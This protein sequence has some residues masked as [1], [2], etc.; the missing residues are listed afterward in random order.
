MSSEEEFSWAGRWQIVQRK[1]WLCIAISLMLLVLMYVDVVVIKD[2]EL[3]YNLYDAIYY[4]YVEERGLADAES[5]QKKNLKTIFE[6]ILLD[7][8]MDHP[9]LG[10][11]GMVGLPRIRFLYSREGT[12]RYPMY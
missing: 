9:G 7:A 11:P 12:C 10:V 2:T 5:V 6:R 1:H 4:N 3:W 8:W